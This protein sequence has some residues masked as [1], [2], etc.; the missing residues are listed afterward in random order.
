MKTPS[1]PLLHPKR[2]LLFMLV[3]STLALNSCTVLKLRYDAWNRSV[4][5]SP[6][7]VL[8]HARP[9]SQGEGDTALLLIHGFG[10]GP[11][12]WKA[13]AAELANRQYHVRA[14][15]LPGWNEPMDVKRSVKADDWEEAVVQEV[16]ALQKE[17]T[18]VVIL[19]HSLGGCV[20]ISATQVGKV[21]PDGLILYAPLL[22][23]SSARSP[24][25]TTR[26]WYKI[27]SCILPD[28][29][30]LESPFPDHVV[31][32]TPRPRT[33]RDPFIPVTLYDELYTVITRV[34]QQES[35]T[36]FP[37]RLILPETD[38]VVDSEVSRAWFQ[39]LQ[40]PGKELHI[41][42][43]TGHVLPLD[44]DPV[45]ESDR[46]SEWLKAKGIMK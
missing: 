26:Q 35:R 31:R 42:E 13:M 20:S 34:E 40:A 46:I 36:S 11:H 8:A 32:A 9:S 5:R 41:A 7:G 27:G 33:E 12:V 24:I 4:H 39:R 3:L 14:M 17:H 45:V 22:R 10:D 38:R 23:V 18:T 29:M 44:L 15:R 21:H 6:D 43:N 2:V 37:V 28:R 16:Q 1:R 25:L 19:A 30:I